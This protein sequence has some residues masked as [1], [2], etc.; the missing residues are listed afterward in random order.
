M[1]YMTY[2]RYSH[3]VQYICSTWKQINFQVIHNDMFMKS[4]CI[5]WNR[6]CLLTSVDNPFKC[7]RPLEY[8]YFLFVSVC[9][10]IN[11]QFL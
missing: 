5:R 9:S 8:S 1:Q 3:A 6:K 7:R 2:N 4:I 10:D 11:E